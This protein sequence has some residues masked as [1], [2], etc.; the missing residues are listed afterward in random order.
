MPQ[1]VDHPLAK[2]ILQHP[3]GYYLNVQPA[4]FPAGEIRGQL[5][6]R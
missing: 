3:E 1:V 2:A 5:S 4:K 6:K